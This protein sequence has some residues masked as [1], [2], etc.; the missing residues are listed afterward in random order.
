[1]PESGQEPSSRRDPDVGPRRPDDRTD[2][3]SNSASCTPGTALAP[4]RR[5]AGTSESGPNQGQLTDPGEVRFPDSVSPAAPPCTRPGRRCRRDPHGRCPHCNSAARPQAARPRP[6]SAP[7]PAEPTRGAGARASPRTHHAGRRHPAQAL[8]SPLGKM[9]CEASSSTSPARGSLPQAAIAAQGSTAHPAGSGSG[10]VTGLRNVWAGARGGRGRG[11][12]GTLET[13]CCSS[14]PRSPLCRECPAV[15]WQPEPP[16]SHL[17][18][19]GKNAS[20]PNAPMGCGP[21]NSP[22]GGLRKRGISSGDFCLKRR[23]RGVPWWGRG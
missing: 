15:T 7:R 11:S 23:L 16:R 9:S 17:R 10:H 3:I 4:R 14:R 13:P 20:F 6:S 18:S 12:G 21:R 1:M 2:R 5:R 19:V 22:C 8:A